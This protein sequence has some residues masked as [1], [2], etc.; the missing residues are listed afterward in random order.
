MRVKRVITP[1]IFFVAL[2]FFTY[3]LSSQY[4]NTIDKNNDEVIIITDNKLT[5][6]E[7]YNDIEEP[8]VMSLSYTTENYNL[9][10]DFLD[11]S[12][13]EENVLESIEDTTADEDI[14]IDEGKYS[15][16]AVSIAKKYVN[17]R[18]NP[19]AN[20]EIVGELYKGSV[21]T[22]LDK[23]GDWY[24][25]NS[26][27]IK[28]FVSSKYIATGLSD[29]NIIK[30][31]SFKKIIVTSNAL[32][33]R[34]EPNLD[35]EQVSSIYKGESYKVENINEDWLQIFLP[36]TNS[37]AYV[38][39]DYVDIITDFNYAIKYEPPE[40]NITNKENTNKNDTSKKTTSKSQR[41]DFDSSADELKLLACLIYSEAS[42]Q[43]Y[44]GKLAVGNVVLNRVNSKKYPNNIKNVIYQKGQFSVVSM[45]ILEK[46]LSNYN[47]FKSSAQKDSIKA[48]KEALSGINNI[49]NRL[50]FN[51]YK[52]A[53]K[54]GHD[55][56]SNS[57]KID[58]QLFW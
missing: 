2:I 41:E 10:L 17:I 45:G 8:S 19:N 44:D 34:K 43:S 51:A 57:V 52:P 23:D 39:I 27:G 11:L 40:E 29:E 38:C 32:K 33:V 14:T 12:S 15:D 16:L 13:I 24:H 26:G 42:G 3:L 37:T 31:Y 25:I 47:D 1:N 22:I 9:N 55:K 46:H 53:V 54:S 49:D 6:Q 58:G 18:K 50:Y 7:N 20:S 36:Q 48:A 4:F 28:G 35:S 30:N 5:E 56:N 21:A